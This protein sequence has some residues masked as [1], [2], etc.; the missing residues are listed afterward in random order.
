LDKVKR[1]RSSFGV[2]CRTNSEETQTKMPKKK[3]P[4]NPATASRHITEEVRGDPLRTPLARKRGRP[5]ATTAI[6]ALPVTVRAELDSLLASGVPVP[7]VAVW[8][9]RQPGMLD[10]QGKCTISEQE[11]YYYRQNYIKKFPIVGGRWAA[12]FLRSLGVKIDPLLTLENAVVVQM[13]RLGMM[14]KEEQER[15]VTLVQTGEEID[16]LDR[17]SARVHRMKQDLGILPKAP[18]GP[19]S[20]AV[21]DK[22]GALQGVGVMGPVPVTP[23]GIKQYREALVRGFTALGMDAA[24]KEIAEGPR[25]ARSAGRPAAGASLEEKS[26]DDGD[27]PVA[28]AHADQPGDAETKPD[29][30]GDGKATGHA[31]GGC[32]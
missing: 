7:G 25:E 11:L 2:H 8:L 30:V 3:P 12:R 17:L 14:L 10:E 24:A 31:Q 15:T 6:H 5:E 18:Q 16:R 21:F 32:A 26:A 13:A 20:T 29:G 19:Q 23:E 4:V 22:S 9:A 27:N 28:G 1:E